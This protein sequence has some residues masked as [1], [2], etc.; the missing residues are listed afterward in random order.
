MNPNNKSLE[1]SSS[2]FGKAIQ[3]YEA[4]GED[5]FIEVYIDDFEPDD[6][7]VAYLLR[8]YSDWPEIE[9]KAVELC[10]GLVLEIGALAGQHALYLQAQGCDVKVC[11]IDPIA[12]NR[13]EEKGFEVMHGDVYDYKGK[14]TFDHVLLMMNGMGMCGHLE[15]LAHFIQHCFTFLKPGGSIIAD[16]SQ[17]SFLEEAGYNMDSYYGEV[18][19]KLQ[20]NQLV[21]EPFPWLFVDYQ[22]LAKIC[23]EAGFPCEKIMEDEESLHYLVKIT[24]PAK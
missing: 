2:V 16:S 5:Q 4:Q 22:T 18:N 23:E 12:S 1:I 6:I 19:Y 15:N 17:L 8:E 11:E 3:A 10:S 20:Y 24:K 13:L 9:K 21:S 14:E 7:S